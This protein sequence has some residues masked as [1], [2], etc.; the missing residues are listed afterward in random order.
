MIPRKTKI[1][2]LKTSLRKE[3]VNIR[4]EIK[5]IGTNKIANSS[6]NKKSGSLKKLNIEKKYYKKKERKYPGCWWGVNIDVDCY[7]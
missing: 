1:V 6:W 3:F 2:Q 7:D 5:E 4:A